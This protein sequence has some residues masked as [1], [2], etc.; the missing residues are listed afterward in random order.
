VRSGIRIYTS[1]I[2]F[3][4]GRPADWSWLHEIS[5]RLVEFF[6]VGVSEFFAQL[7]V[8][9]ARFLGDGLG[10]VYLPGHPGILASQP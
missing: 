5:H 1:F 9:L 7:F 6:K 3:I 4:F 8:F 2:S 10:F